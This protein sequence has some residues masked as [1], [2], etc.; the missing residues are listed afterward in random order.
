MEQNKF[1]KVSDLAKKVVKKYGSGKQLDMVQEECAELIA[2]ISH[3]KRKRVNSE[4]E[5][6]EE[7]ADVAFMIYQLMEI[8]PTSSGSLVSMIV[9][10]CEKRGLME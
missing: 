5:V 3:L 10:K 1:I 2:A 4:A 7:M 8:V 9:E 6:R